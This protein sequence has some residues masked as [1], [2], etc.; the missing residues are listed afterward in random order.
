MIQCTWPEALE[1]AKNRRDNK[2]YNIAY[3]LTCTN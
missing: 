1:N 3:A 2:F